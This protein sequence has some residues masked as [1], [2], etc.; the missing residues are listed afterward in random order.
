MSNPSMNCVRNLN[1]QPDSRYKSATNNEQTNLLT[2]QKNDECLA[3]IADMQEYSSEPIVHKSKCS[4]DSS[5]EN[6]S[7]NHAELE[8]SLVDDFEYVDI[9]ESISAGDLNIDDE[10]IIFENQQLSP[11]SPNSVDNSNIKLNY[12]TQ[13]FGLSENEPLIKNND[14]DKLCNSIKVLPEESVTINEIPNSL[15][16]F[17]LI[18]LDVTPNESMCTNMQLI[19]P[20]LTRASLQVESSASKSSY[21]SSIWPCKYN[22]DLFINNSDCIDNNIDV[23]GFGLNRNLS[24][25]F[26]LNVLQDNAMPNIEVIHDLETNSSKLTNI[27]TKNLLVNPIEDI[28][29]CILENIQECT[30][31]E[32]QSL[33]SIINFGPEELFTG[34]DLED[35]LLTDYLSDL[36]DTSNTTNELLLPQRHLNIKLSQASITPL[37]IDDEKTKIET[38][39]MYKIETERSSRKRSFDLST[40]CKKQYEEVNKHKDLD[41]KYFNLPCSSIDQTD[42]AHLYESEQ[43]KMNIDLDVLNIKTRQKK[44]SVTISHKSSSQIIMHQL[45]SQSHERF[46]KNNTKE[47]PNSSDI[48]LVKKNKVVP[49]SLINP[50]KRRTKYWKTT[51]ESST[52]IVK[53]R[54][55]KK[56]SGTPYEESSM[57]K[58]KLSSSKAY[59]HG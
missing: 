33:N 56:D 54:T 59:K 42:S 26:T 9:L 13:L 34:K 57:K 24:D 27:L 20:H 44:P 31:N 41:S 58:R 38:V 2:L 8:A 17:D 43:L 19:N 10:Q 30:T 21:C 4:L 35:S 7:K 6:E 32:S 37:T 25:D 12:I 50:G 55:V 18:D 39:G 45:K 23:V 3:S 47:K 53:K 22:T 11:I 29:S 36:N 14:S 51:A 5:L 28:H 40:E 15:F 52:K 1:F 49:K 16:D 46:C 48:L